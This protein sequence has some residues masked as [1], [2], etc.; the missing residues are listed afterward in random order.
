MNSQEFIISG[1]KI[2]GLKRGYQP[3]LAFRLRVSVASVK[4]YASGKRKVPP[5]VSELMAMILKYEVLDD[6]KR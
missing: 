2:T 6:S 4:R 1:Q 5:C 3:L